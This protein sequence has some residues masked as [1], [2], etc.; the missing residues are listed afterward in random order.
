MGHFFFFYLLFDAQELHFP[1]R[2]FLPLAVIFFF[3]FEIQLLKSQFFVFLIS[4]VTLPNSSHTF[5]LLS[6]TKKKLAVE[7]DAETADTHFRISNSAIVAT[8]KPKEQ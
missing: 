7:R 3:F 4:K 8:P 1:F 6:S 5:S 2:L